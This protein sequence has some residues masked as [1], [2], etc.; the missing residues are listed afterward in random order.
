MRIS[1]HR[2]AIAVALLSAALIAVPTAPAAAT[3]D[4]AYRTPVAH[5]AAAARTSVAAPRLSS[6]LRKLFRRV[7]RSGAFVLDANSGQVLFSQKGGRPR[8][9]ASNTKV[10]TTATALARF[11]P[12]TRLETAVWSTD[13]V[14]DGISQGLY[15]R[16]G[17]DPTLTGNGLT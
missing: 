11:E 13:N 3:I 14:S 1:S 15:L 5:G 8:I 16:G 9:L 2:G 7:G 12:Q 6:G 4:R 10:F 17:G